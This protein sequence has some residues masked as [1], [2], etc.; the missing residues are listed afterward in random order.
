MLQF[1]ITRLSFLLVA[2]TY[3]GASAAHADDACRKV[4]AAYDVGTSSIKLSAKLID[5]CKSEVIK[6]IYSGGK[7][8]STFAAQLAAATID[9]P[10]ALD[11]EY[12]EKNGLPTFEAAKKFVTE[13]VAKIK[14]ENGNSYA[15]DQHAGIATHVF[16]TCSNCAP[17]L[18]SLLTNER[19]SGLDI[20]IIPQA[21]EGELEFAGVVRSLRPGTDPTKISSWGIGDG[22][23][24]FVALAESKAGVQ[25]QLYYLSSYASGTFKTALVEKLGRT[26]NSP[27]PISNETNLRT[28][29]SDYTVAS[30]LV[31]ALFD[32]AV[33]KNKSASFVDWMTTTH[34]IVYGVGGVHTGAIKGALK[35]D[36]LLKSDDL[37]AFYLITDLEAILTKFLGLKDGEIVEKMNAKDFDG[38]TDEEKEKLRKNEKLLSY[39]RGQVSSMILV[40]RTALKLDID[41]VY[42]SN[43][44]G[45]GEIYFMPEFAPKAE[46]AEK[47]GSV[48]KPAPKPT[49]PTKAELCSRFVVKNAS[50]F[51]LSARSA[52]GAIAAMG[53]IE[54]A[55]GTVSG[56]I[57]Q[58]SI[59]AKGCEALGMI[60]DA[61]TC[62][63]V[64]DIP[65]NTSG[66]RQM[67][68]YIPLK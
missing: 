2:L 37:G 20:R 64:V 21:R 14:D 57:V 41:R 32:Q 3:F 67:M 55:N 25:K 7:V 29:K 27:N 35:L 18:K 12:W 36:K 6:D 44:D 15:I 62:Y 58:K 54:R 19:T 66:T 9:R 16:R 26:E 65:A 31:D 10:Q 60:S 52:A 61:T 4:R 47:V 28:N 38:K 34:P 46:P 59:S 48:E 1:R 24:Q 23:Q 53:T 33:A 22:S 13:E 45:T 39:A 17:L 68:V 56:C 50:K 42:L 8:T 51:G 43:A 49:L 40:Y 5:V 30:E 63:G 11:L